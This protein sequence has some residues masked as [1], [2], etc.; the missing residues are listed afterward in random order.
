MGRRVG[1]RERNRE[2]SKSVLLPGKGRYLRIV[3]VLRPPV[4]GRLV[5]LPSIFMG[6]V[7]IVM[8]A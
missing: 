3:H 7:K 8:L 2:G 5:L 4:L 1:R 6:K